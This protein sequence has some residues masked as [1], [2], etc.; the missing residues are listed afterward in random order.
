MKKESMFTFAK[1][2]VKQGA[3]ENVLSLL[4]E[5]IAKSSAE[6]GNLTY[7]VFQGNDNSHTLMLFEEYKD[8]KALDFHRNSEHFKK[9]IV[10][11]I[12]PLL[13]NREVI[14]MSELFYI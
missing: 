11:Q 8:Q 10:Q 13:E 9:I 12:V 2:Q 5:A 1:W 14:V 4:K 7:Q 6:E 3:L